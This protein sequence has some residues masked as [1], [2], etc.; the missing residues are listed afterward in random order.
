MGIDIFIALFPIY[1]INY[2]FCSEIKPY[3]FN[4]KELLKIFKESNR[5]ESNS[6]KDILDADKTFNNLK[7]LSICNINKKSFI[8]SISNFLCKNTFY[9]YYVKIKNIDSRYGDN[10]H[11]KTSKYIRELNFIC[12]YYIY[13]NSYEIIKCYDTINRLDPYYLGFEIEK[14]YEN[15]QKENG[16]NDF[17]VSNNLLKKSEMLFEKKNDPFYYG[18]DNNSNKPLDNYSEL[19]Q[20]NNVENVN[21]NYLCKLKMNI[22]SYITDGESVILK[23]LIGLCIKLGYK[24]QFFISENTFALVKYFEKTSVNHIFN[25]GFDIYSSKFYHSKDIYVMKSMNSF[26]NSDRKLIR[27]NIPNIYFKFFSNKSYLLW[28]GIEKKRE[29][30]NYKLLELKNLLEQVNFK[31]RIT[32][33]YKNYL[34]VYYEEDEKYIKKK[35]GSKIKYSNF[36][37]LNNSKLSDFFLLSFEY[38]CDNNVLSFEQCI[39]NI[40]SS[41][42]LDEK[43]KSIMHQFSYENFL[44]FDSCSY[45]DHMNIFNND[46]IIKKLQHYINRSNS[47]T[48]KKK[49]YSKKIKEKI[50]KSEN[51]DLLFPQDDNIQKDFFENTMFS[52]EFDSVTSL[53]I[54]ELDK[55]NLK[56]NLESKICNILRYIK[57]HEK[58]YKRENRRY[59]NRTLEESI[60][61]NNI[62]LEH[63]KNADFDEFIDNAYDNIKLDNFNFSMKDI[64]DKIIDFDLLKYDN[65][66]KEDNNYENLEEEKNYYEQND[67]THDELEEYNNF[68]NYSFPEKHPEE[69]SLMIHDMFGIKDIKENLIKNKITMQ[70]LSI[71]GPDKKEIFTLQNQYEC[72]I[73]QKIYKE[74]EMSKN[75]D[76]KNNN[77]DRKKEFLKYFSF[78]SYYNFTI[79][80]VPT[81]FYDILKNQTVKNNDEKRNSNFSELQKKN[82]KFLCTSDNIWPYSKTLIKFFQNGSIYCEAQLEN[83]LLI[84][85]KNEEQTFQY[86]LNQIK[87]NN[88]MLKDKEKNKYN[89]KNGNISKVYENNINTDTYIYP[90]NILYNIRKSYLGENPSTKS[91]IIG[92]Q[93]LNKTCTIK[94]IGDDK[95]YINYPILSKVLLEAVFG[96][97]ILHGFTT[98]KI[99]A[100]T[101]NFETGIK[102]KFYEILLNG[103]TEYE[104]LGL[105]LM[106]VATFSKELYYIITGY[107]LKNNLLLSA[108]AKFDENLYVHHNIESNFFNYMKKKSMNM[109]HNLRF[110]CNEDYYPYK[111]CYD[112]YPLVK[113]NKENYCYFETND[114]F[115][116]LNELFPDVCKMGGS[117]GKCYEQIKKNITCSNNSEGCKYYNFITYT[118]IKP[119]RKTSYFINHNMSVHEYLSK[120][121][122]KYYL[123]LCQLIKNEKNHLKEY[124]NNEYITDSQT[125][126]LLNYILQNSTFFIF[127]NFSTEFWRRFQYIHKKKN[128]DD[129]FHSKNHTTFCPMAY[130]YEFIYHLNTFYIKE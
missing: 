47:L 91:K 124:G 50:R 123:I 74:Y 96:L 106:N 102:T 61:L 115:K 23:I 19:N 122:Y 43:A 4:K 17:M 75:N 89:D 93:F 38:F 22:N 57:Y 45:E 44:C 73:L 52:L 7:L 80:N 6:E 13:D 76:Y 81:K 36:R 111:N 109:L 65:D 82:L 92:F 62:F 15:K 31:E 105:K 113:K 68:K 2:L 30:F 110:N 14:R 49:N 56:E 48:F 108:V 39:S 77:K 58:L 100:E 59:N 130:S 42:I 104:H 33:C 127:W 125:Y 71:I 20:S 72:D 51:S 28:R 78:N 54:D 83:E 117:V 1:F 70:H 53:I 121:S 26:I 60:L 63:S 67:Y 35:L 129:I 32:L 88:D 103:I 46:M 107:T 21:V 94:Y 95:Y 86:L 79:I 64:Q 37:S 55:L 119:R 24:N 5:I 27:K 116:E 126:F 3:D 120:K 41:K 18:N 8:N 114:I 85:I 11:S 10:V 25:L 34:H 99:E 66:N 97:C 128:E 84:N 98:L 9:T 90:E 29:I 118:F 87:E 40:M 12:K 112:I 101:L 16:Y 69:L